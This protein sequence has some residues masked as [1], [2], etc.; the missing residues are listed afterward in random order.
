ML[1]EDNSNPAK[2]FTIPESFLDKM[3]EFTGNGED[4][5]FILAYVNQDGKAM[6]QCKI[7]SQIIEMGL[8]KAL[9]RF[10]QDMEMG[11]KAAMDDGIDPDLA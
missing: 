5:G 3:F 6:I 11:E 4:G 8:R 7:S 9:E 2:A 1:Q 10:L